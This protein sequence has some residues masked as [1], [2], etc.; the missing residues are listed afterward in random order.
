MAK[1]TAE[2]RKALMAQLS[3]VMTPEQEAEGKRR[4]ALAQ[5]AVP[6]AVRAERARRAWAARRAKAAAHCKQQTPTVSPVC[7]D[8]ASEPDNASHADSRNTENIDAIDVA[9][10]GNED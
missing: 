8:T 10:T 9:K 3:A 6:P 5:A 1:L 2:Q 7:P 4:S